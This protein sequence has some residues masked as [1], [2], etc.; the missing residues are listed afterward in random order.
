MILEQLTLPNCEPEEL[1]LSQQDFPASP[2]VLPESKKGL[3]MKEQTY[4]VTLCELFAQWEPATSSW[5]TSQQSSNM[6][7]KSRENWPKHVTFSNGMLFRRKKSELVTSA[8]GGG[9]SVRLPT[10]ISIDSNSSC[11]PNNCGGGNIGWKIKQLSPTPVASE[12]GG[13]HVYKQGGHNLQEGVKRLLTPM[14]RDYKGPTGGKRK[15]LQSL[16]DDLKSRDR[17]NEIES[18]LY[19]LI[20]L[21]SHYSGIDKGGVI[22]LNPRAL[23][24]MMGYGVGWCDLQCDNPSDPV[25]MTP[26]DV[27]SCLPVFTL[28]KPCGRKNEIKA[29]GNSLVPQC[30]SRLFDKILEM[31]KK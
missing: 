1:T 24:A 22:R 31:E 3:K 7:R 14:S 8:K 19:N 18:D 5:K 12:T 16:P 27:E 9:V 11:R 20:E 30:A 6:P 25:L 10:P 21:Y 23:E 4:S 15:T 13:V 29:M 2:L 26:D 17:D 28:T